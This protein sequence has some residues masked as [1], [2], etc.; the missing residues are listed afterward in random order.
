MTTPPP[1]KPIDDQPSSS[2]LVST[3]AGVSGETKLP[4]I[5]P[6]DT[7]QRTDKI[8]PRDILPGQFSGTQT[9]SFGGTSGI[10]I[11]PT[12]GL[13]IGANT[14]AAAPFSVDKTGHATLSSLSVSGLISVGGAAADINANST[15][16]QGGKLTANSVTA[17]KMVTGTITAASGIINDINAGVIST[18]TLDASA[19]SVIHLSATNVDAG[20][21]TGITV[22]TASSGKRVVLN[23]SADQVEIY[24]SSAQVVTMSGSAGQFIMNAPT[25]KTL[26]FVVNGGSGGQAFVENNS[27]G[28]IVGSYGMQANS[29]TGVQINGPSSHGISLIG[30]TDISGNTFI[31][32]NLDA[33]GTVSAHIKAFDI[34]HPNG[35]ENLRL[36]Y[37][38]LE[39]PEVLVFCR[40]KG[41]VVFPQHF[42]DVSVPGTIQVIKSGWF[43]KRIWFAT[44]VRKGYEDFEPEYTRKVDPEGE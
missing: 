11:D 4:V 14:F 40:G 3:G 30:G 24:D 41:K 5:T 32:G 34:E 1:K 35:I 22:Q 20:T 16:V 39:A 13:Y 44:A 15:L 37:V 26:N 29:S 28:M 8:N 36:K 9:Y 12:K 18:G 38:C 42:I 7:P 33:S 6:A 17:A 10:N 21:L 19:V 25:G 43:W 31:L 23:G 27:V 2:A